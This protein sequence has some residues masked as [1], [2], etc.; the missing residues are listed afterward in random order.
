MVAIATIFA[1]MMA[2]IGFSVS[3]YIVV[4]V[5]IWIAGPLLVVL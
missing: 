3:P 4:Y 1:A 5:S 2:I